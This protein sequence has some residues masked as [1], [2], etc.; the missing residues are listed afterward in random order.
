MF[1]KVVLFK[2]IFFVLFENAFAN[3]ANR[4]HLGTIEIL[5]DKDNSSLFESVQNQTTLT[6]DQLLK[7]RGVSLGETLKNE[8]G[9]TSTQYGPNASRPVIRGLDGDRIRILQNGLGVLDASGASQDHAVPIDPLLM[10]SVEIVRGPLSLLYGSSAVGGVVNVLTN[11]THGDY[12]EGFYGAY[13]SQLTSVDNGKSVGVKADY[14]F[15]RWMFHLD[16]NFRDTQD[17]KINGFA[18]SEALRQALPLPVNQ[19]TR[20]KQSNS[21]SQTRSGGAGATY[22][23]AS[24]I[25]GVSASLYSSDYGTLVDPDIQIA[26]TQSRFDLVSET[27]NIG[28]LK[29]IRIKSAQSIYRHSEI[30]LGV[31]GT[32]FKNNGNETRV[33]FVQK[34]LGNLTGVFGVQS[35][36]FNFS[37][38]GDEAFLPETRNSAQALFGYEE[39]QI[40][41]SKLSFGGRFESNRV[42]P[43]PNSNFTATEEKEFFLGSAG[44]GYLLNISPDWAFSSQLSYSERAP[45]YQ[46]LFSDGAHVATFSYQVGDPTLEKEK[47]SSIEITLRHKNDK[48]NSSLSIFGQQFKDYISLNPTGTFDDT[49]GSSVAGDSPEDLQIYNYISQKAEI[50][51]VEFDTRLLEVF[52]LFSGGADVYFKSDYLRGKNSQTGDNLARMTPPRVFFGLTH[53][54][55][56]LSSDIEFQHVLKQTK[57]A[58][59]ELETDAYS[60]FN[61]G[62]SYKGQVGDKQLSVFARVNNIFNVEARNHV[63]ILKDLSQIGGRNYSIGVRSYF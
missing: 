55:G 56:Q 39:F 29:A 37:A 2:L 35:N 46:E 50:Y 60:Q 49:D 31:P 38:L 19:E 25:I 8:V 12:E 36:I 11:R 33:E 10:D 21:S 18:R 40:N 20:D 27:K 52:N 16:G 4:S 59:N 15:N 24:T 42:K 57:T 23:G 45:N 61:L 58:V 26:M 51:G 13:D 47:V 48:M 53:H 62:L 63:S 1:K 17:Y 5:A 14:G 54:L 28:P 22:V 9:V 32:T 30:E 7:V 41:S 44:V 6:G 3:E 34:A 43:M